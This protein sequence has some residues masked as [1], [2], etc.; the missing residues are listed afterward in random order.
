M[1]RRRF[2]QALSEGDGISVIVVVDGDVAR[3]SLGI[4]QAFRR[5]RAVVP[6]H[7]VSRTVV[8]LGDPDEL[9]AGRPG[10]DPGRDRPLDV[11]KREQ[12]GRREQLANRVEHFN[13]IGT[14]RT[15]ERLKDQGIDIYREASNAQ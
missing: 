2:S 5:I 13:R 6:G 3:P 4:I 11:Q 10:L 12:G 14:N 15:R 8:Y 1:N 9:L 7:L